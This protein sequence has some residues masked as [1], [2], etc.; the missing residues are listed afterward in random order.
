M[1]VKALDMVAGPLC[2]TLGRVWPAQRAMLAKVAGAVATTP[3]P[4]AVGFLP[5]LRDYDLRPTLG[6]IRA[7]T[8]VV[9]GG[10]D[11]SPRRRTPTNWP[12]PSAVLRTYTFHAGHM[13]PT[14]CLAPSPRRSG[15]PCSSAALRLWPITAAASEHKA[16]LNSPDCSE[17]RCCRDCFGLPRL[18][19]PAIRGRGIIMRQLT[20]LDATYPPWTRPR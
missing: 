2:A 19:D 7:H 5:G 14:S 6:R 1:P 12:T 11:P 15:W 4:T 18:G 20:G 17:S 13:L 10:A 9:S 8:V 16:T 3:I